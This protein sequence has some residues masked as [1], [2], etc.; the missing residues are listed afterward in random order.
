MAPLQDSQLLTVVNLNRRLVQTFGA[1]ESFNYTEGLCGAFALALW[2]FLRQ[3]RQRP[4]ILNGGRGAH[5]VVQWMGSTFDVDG[6]QARERWSA[7]HPQTCDYNLAWSRITPARLLQSHTTRR[8][9]GGSSYRVV[10]ASL[11]HTMRGEL[12]DLSFPRY[13]RREQEAVGARHSTNWE[14]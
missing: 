9:I 1:T 2:R 3:K 6:W 7:Q 5:F 14:A 8:K 11:V 12:G 10:V 4:V 13:L